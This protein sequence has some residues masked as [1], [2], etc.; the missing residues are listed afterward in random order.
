MSNSITDYKRGLALAMQTPSVESQGNFKSS[1]IENEPT[2]GGSTEAP[3]STPELNLLLLRTDALI[4]A[5][6]E[7]KGKTRT[8]S[9]TGASLIF[10]RVADP[11]QPTTATRVTRSECRLFDV[12]TLAKNHGGH[13]TRL[14]RWG[15]KKIPYPPP[16]SE[17]RLPRM[18]FSIS[19]SREEGR[20]TDTHT[21][22]LGVCVCVCLPLTLWR[23][24]QQ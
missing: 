23:L 18:I 7:P 6:I 19:P 21:I 8:T 15:W 24:S 1:K 17:V 20:E 9:Q 10:A 16:P 2:A 5:M 11:Y 12:A 13:L 22:P 3:H 14:G 4:T